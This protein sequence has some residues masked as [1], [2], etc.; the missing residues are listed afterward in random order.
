MDY[1][2]KANLRSAAAGIRAFTRQLGVRLRATAPFI[3]PQAPQFWDALVIADAFD[4]AFNVGIAGLDADLPWSCSFCA[5]LVDE[6][7]YSRGLLLQTLDVAIG[8]GL[9]ASNEDGL[10]LKQLLF[11]GYCRQQI[12]VAYLDYVGGGGIGD[13]WGYFARVGA[14]I[15]G[16]SGRRGFSS[17]YWRSSDSFYIFCNCE[18]MP[19]NGISGARQIRQRLGLCPFAPQSASF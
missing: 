7:V 11:A 8:F 1:T 3:E 5:A 13:T 2:A 17:F 9:V 19:G 4:R 15:A 14:M 10:N 6:A 18:H 16:Q 12:V